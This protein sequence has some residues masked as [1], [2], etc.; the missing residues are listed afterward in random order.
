LII[1]FHGRGNTGAG[2]EEFSGLSTLPA[3][4][5][6]PN[7]VIGTG[8]GDR[9]AWEGAPYAAAGVDDVAFTG[10]LLDS[11]EPPGRCR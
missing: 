10:D 9:Q 5:A 4:V 1:A 11:L 6:Y 3:V 2:T 7:G 8:D